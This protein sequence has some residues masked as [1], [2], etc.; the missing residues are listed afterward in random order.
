[1]TRKEYGLSNI[2]FDKELYEKYLTHLDYA[3]LSGL[4]VDYVH[5]WKL[6]DAMIWPRENFHV[7]ANFTNKDSRAS[8]L[9]T[10]RYK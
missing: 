4:T 6:G 10:T 2:P 7:S 3:G 9:I 5:E 8:V 1:M